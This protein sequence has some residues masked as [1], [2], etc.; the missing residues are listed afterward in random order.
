MVAALVQYERANARLAGAP[1]ANPGAQFPGGI[2]PA[3]SVRSDRSGRRSRQAGGVHATAPP[4][5]DPMSRLNRLFLMQWTDPVADPRSSVLRATTNG[6]Y[7]DNSRKPAL[8]RPRSTKAMRWHDAIPYV[9]YGR[10]C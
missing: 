8:K 4:Q 3:L 2:S 1:G 6:V 7:C 5:Q 10:D 9:S